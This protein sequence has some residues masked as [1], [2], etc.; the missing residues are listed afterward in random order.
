MRL[1]KKLSRLE[2][3]NSHKKEVEA[4][5]SPA[6]SKQWKEKEVIRKQQVRANETQAET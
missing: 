1:H 5:Q 4:N 3:I 6:E 2:Q